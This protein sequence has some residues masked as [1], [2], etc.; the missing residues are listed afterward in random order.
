MF[1]EQVKSYLG[2]LNELALNTYYRRQLA[3]AEKLFR[4][5]MEL[6]DQY[7]VQGL[8]LGSRMNLSSTCTFIGK[9][10]ESEQLSFEALS[11]LEKMEIPDSLKLA[12]KSLMYKNLGINYIYMDYVEKA[13]EYHLKDEKICREIYHDSHMQYLRC[14]FNLAND[15]I[16]LRR[17]D[18]AE[19]YLNTL[20]FKVEEL[21][22]LDYD[23]RAE[24][25]RTSAVNAF[26][27]MN[28]EKAYNLGYKGYKLRSEAFLKEL[29]LMPEEDAIKAYGHTR[30]TGQICLSSY[31]NMK[32][33]ERKQVWSDVP[34]IFCTV[35]GVISDEIYNRKQLLKQLNDSSI[36]ELIK[37]YESI[38][39][40]LLSVYLNRY[41]LGD[42]VLRP[43]VDSL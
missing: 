24:I 11:L 33:E 22:E 16:Q 3:R 26:H 36:K 38:R 13:L 7:N 5:I 14:L 27:R 31:L 6:S 12:N 10:K 8:R 29:V 25:Y 18:Q 20:L 4:E 9:L 19:S 41:Q 42:S 32:D 28:F 23:F 34:V 1:P 43:Y 15:N 21:T 2:V 40:E 37:I 30:S 39:L 17:F 35:K